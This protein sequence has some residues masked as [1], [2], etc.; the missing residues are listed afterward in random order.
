MKKFFTRFLLVGLFL[1]FASALSFAQTTL[2]GKITDAEGEP[3]PGANVYIKG[4]N[5]GTISNPDGTFSLTTSNALPL[6]LQVS[7]VGFTGQ[8]IEVKEAG[9][10]TVKLEEETMGEG[11]VVSA[12]RVEENIM[13]S[14]VTI[15]K[16]DI[17]AV[18]QAPTP[19]FYDGLARLK[20]VSSTPGSL[21]FNSINTRGFA[22]INNTRFV[23]LIDGMDN[24]S[25][26][27]NFPTGNVVGISDLD[28]ESVELVPGAGS[29]L[30][31][32]NAFNGILFM[33][34]K[35][36]FEYQGL[37]ATLK[38]G[39]TQSN[40]APGGNFYG[41]NLTGNA[42]AHGRNSYTNFAIRYA[43]SFGNRFAFKVNA[44]ILD[45]QDWRANNYDVLR[46]GVTNYDNPN[47]ANP[48]VNDR[49]NFDGLNT[50]GDEVPLGLPITSTTANAFA[51]SFIANPAFASTLNNPAL[52]NGNTALA[53]TALSSFFQNVASKYPN[54]TI[55]LPRLG[56]KEENL[57]DNQ[58]AR[59][60]KFD[61][62]AHYRI[63]DNLELIGNFRYGSGSSVY[64]GGN[65]YAL[66]D[67]NIMFSKLELKGKNFF[68]RA[69]MSQSDAGKSYNLDA[70]GLLLTSSIMGKYI[71]GNFAPAFA[72]NMVQNFFGTYAGTGVTPT[73]EQ[74]NTVRDNSYNATMNAIP[75]PGSQAY[76][77][78]V[79]DI[80]GKRFKNGG[81]SFL[82]NSRLYHAEFNYNFKDVVTFMDLQ[83]GGNVR[84]YDLFS[85]NTVFRE[86]NGTSIS[87]ITIDEFGG[88]VQAGKSLLDDRLKITASIRYDKNQNFQGQVNPRASVVYSLGEKKQHNIR[89]SYQTGF[90]NPETQA[91]FIYFPSA[92]GILL[93]GTRTNAEAFGIFEGG[94]YTDR[95]NPTGSVIN[96]DYIQPEKLQAYEVGY[97]GV[98]MDNKLMIDFNVYYNDYTNFI[99]QRTVYAIKGGS[100]PG[101]DPFAAGAAFRPYV[102]SKV[103]IQS[104]G[105]GLGFTYR[106]P[107]G[108]NLNGSY[109]FADFQA[110][111]STDPTFEPGFNTPKHKFNIGIANREV[112]KNVGFDISYRWQ[113]RFLWQSSFG[114]GY[115]EA[116]GV[117]DAQ[118]SYKVKEMKSVLKLGASNLLGKLNNDYFGKDYNA[119]FGGPYVGQL[120]YFSITF[121]EF[122]R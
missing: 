31:G 6:T 72:Q 25:P 93:G 29:A 16:M 67:F 9:E 118:V 75:Q 78:A 73:V 77:D 81:A 109:S 76:K 58:N 98:M 116:F 53:Q 108:Y 21:T 14:P 56:H 54:G 69:Y 103:P 3:L 47:N 10:I 121:D 64:Q 45:G 61:A 97:K 84:R 7:F 12:S 22:A 8:D 74:I 68:V 42:Q 79:E 36:P 38:L 44:S 51:N 28:V 5:F 92:S 60:Y 88:Y 4:T 23:Q 17:I 65:R 115:V 20:G 111:L 102:N 83:V 52:F 35:S 57:V 119:S 39:S 34:S 30:Y 11:V 110:D 32:P 46:T 82:D 87:R 66:R 99:A 24:A 86:N 85:D 71:P 105:S 104:W 106:L 59:S 26:L 13:K 70:I 114:N 33:N 18:Q 50:Y 113:D 107:K 62:A 63:N 55:P 112:W 91:Q 19:D 2:T 90:R 27:L 95:A 101:T 48:T 89:A 80:R 117:V 100:V 1:V 41:N 49:F 37:S 120:Y 122:F 96:L 94:A 43:K 40:A 15:E